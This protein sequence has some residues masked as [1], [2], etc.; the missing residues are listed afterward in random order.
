MLFVS[1]LINM[2]PATLPPSS[3]R[4]DLHVA[5]AS[6]AGRQQIHFFDSLPVHCDVMIVSL[7]GGRGITWYFVFGMFVHL[8]SRL[9]PS[10]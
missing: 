9:I 8:I 1:T 3:R 6:T 2:L 7:V 10:S 5:T 4:I